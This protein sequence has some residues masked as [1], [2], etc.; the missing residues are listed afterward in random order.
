MNMVNKINM[1]RLFSLLL[2]YPTDE[3]L[4][5][6][7][8]MNEVEGL[9]SLEAFNSRSLEEL[10][11]EYTNLFINSY[12]ALLC[13]PY[14][15]YYREGLVYGET[16][17]NVLKCYKTAKLDYAYEGEPPD[18]ISV[19]L[20]FIAETG[21]ESFLKRLKEWVPSFL[22]K[23]KEQSSVYSAIARDMERM[24]FPGDSPVTG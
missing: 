18:H 11:V 7:G 22:E 13:P 16:T 5:L 24:L 12:P 21:D 9:P 8:E 3:V 19:E 14:E 6:T 4:D 17:S 10:Q 2:S 15:S 1:F 23:V 20:E